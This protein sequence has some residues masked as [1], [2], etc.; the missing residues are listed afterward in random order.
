MKPDR[1]PAVD[2]VR[3]A[4]LIGIAVVNLP[5]MALP[6]QA[7]LTLPE[8]W[9]DRLAVQ[10]TELLFQ[11]KF[12]LLFS[13][14]FGWGLEIQ[15]L[16]ARRAGASFARRYS[17]RLGMLALFGIL[18]A[19]LVFTGDILLLYAVLGLIAWALKGA[20]VRGLLGMAMALVP[21][22][23][24]CLAVIVVVLADAPLPPDH[25]GLGGS[26]VETVL[27]RWRDW[28]PVFVFLVLFQG[29][30][31]LAAF[32]VGMAA[33]RTGF[34][35][36]GNAA[37]ARLARAVPF[38]LAAGLIV[39]LVYVGAGRSEALPVAMAG[40]ASLA[41]GGPLLAA[42]YLG[43][44]LRVARTVRMPAFVVVAGRNTLTC[45]VLQG[46]LAGLV[47]GGYGLGLFG[48]L[49]QMTILALSVA[50]ALLSMALVAAW[51]QRFGQGPLEWLLRRV[52]LA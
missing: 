14:V 23:A 12:F 33:A 28:P 40:L 6:S 24:A 16:Q 3:A 1:N 51:A 25:P 44:I 31:A 46:V 34:F 45:Y 42:A 41:L 17:R 7:L 36:E 4:A 48:D 10:G 50:I 30:L 49:G 18:H 35:E 37:A 11:A 26:Y 47:L 19:L 22:A 43:L 52:T 27:A 38:L 5:F 15:S 39:N 9:P 8:A 21:V 32:L 29:H 13:F 20:S 2:L